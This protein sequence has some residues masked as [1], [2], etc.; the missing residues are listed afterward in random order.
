MQP[1][2]LIE[3][4]FQ[5]EVECCC[6]AKNMRGKDCTLDLMIKLSL[7]DVYHIALLTSDSISNKKRD[8]ERTLK[9]LFDKNNFKLMKVIT[10]FY[11]S[12][13]ECNIFSCIHEKFEKN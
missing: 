11:I 1:Q 5:E 2:H 12:G 10:A 9:M 4:C 3:D 8:K 7:R 13:I 6:D